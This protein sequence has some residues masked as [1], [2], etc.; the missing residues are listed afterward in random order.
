[1]HARPTTKTLIIAAL[2]TGMRL[3]ELLSLRFGDVDLDRQ[4]IFVRPENAM[5]KRGRCSGEKDDAASVI[6]NRVGEPLRDFRDG[7]KDALATANVTGLW[8]HD[9]RVA[10]RLVERGVPLSRSP[11]CW[12]TRRS[13]P[14]SGTTGSDSRRSR[15]PRNAWTK[16]N[17]STFFQL[18]PRMPPTPR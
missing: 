17:L 15:P 4:V 7:W 6:S 10:S 12:G 18:R 8:F 14:R 9:L 1:M 5:S 3:G 13:S 2:D 16:V 11:T